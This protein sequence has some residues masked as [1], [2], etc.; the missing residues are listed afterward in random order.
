VAPKGIRSL[1]LFAKLR[2]KFDMTKFFLS[3]CF[4]LRKLFPP[5]QKKIVS[6]QKICLMKTTKLP[7]NATAEEL[8]NF[9]AV[10][11]MR[12]QRDR[13]DAMFAKMTD[14]EIIAYLNNTGAKTPPQRS[15]KRLPLRKKKEFA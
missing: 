11:F 8:K 13:L 9:D 15:V 7:N 10:G 2:K 12:E 14:K 1:K 6:L 5:Y 4:F 3:D